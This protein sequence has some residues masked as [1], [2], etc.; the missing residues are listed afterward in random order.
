MLKQL[1]VGCA[2]VVAALGVAACG[3]SEEAA[4]SG[5]TRTVAAG[6]PI[7]VGQ[8][9]A[10]TGWLKPYD[11]ALAIGAKIKADEINEAG[12]VNGHR[13]E[14]MSADT[15]TDPTQGGRAAQELLD[16]G[17]DVLMATC[18]YDHGAPVARVAE[19]VSKITL[20]C[21]GGVGLGVQGVGPY[22]YN[23]YPGSPTEGAVLA[24]WAHDEGFKSP[25]LLNLK[26]LEYTDAICS[27]FEKTWKELNPNGKIAGKDVVSS[28]DTAIDS[29]ISRI[30]SADADVLILCSLPPSGASAL[31][32]IRAAGITMP[33]GGAAAF[34]G[35][36]WLRGVPNLSDFYFPTTG[37]LF[38][39]DPNPRHEELFD[40]IRVETGS[41]PDVAVYALMGYSM[42]EAYAK[43]IEESGSTDPDKIKA[44][45]DSFTDE[46]LMLGEMTFTPECHIS[47]GAAHLLM[48]VQD[49]KMKYS[50]KTIKPEYVPPAAC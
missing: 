33:I 35:D 13:I 46:P 7:V 22:T 5:G 3:T 47:H 8:A 19:A 37:S 39:D 6:E 44:V 20:G 48:E 14:F 50:G 2:F 32:Q 24:Q 26:E 30:R 43:G 36:Y 38:G 16:K 29:Q 28:K 40:Q 17:A 11:A 49:G 42:I 27:S 4:S 45:L 12:G 15:R 31:K 9:L 1:A 34:D 21:A 41:R 23:F 10:R 18:D 25:Y